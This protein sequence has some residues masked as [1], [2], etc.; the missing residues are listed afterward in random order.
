MSQVKDD[1]LNTR[2]CEL[3]G[4]DFPIVSAGMGFVARAE[5]AAAVSNAGGLGVIGGAG[6]APERLRFEI[7]KCRELTDRP[8]GVDLIL[9]IQTTGDVLPPR[10]VSERP[11]QMTSDDYDDGHGEFAIQHGRR[12]PPEESM[13]VVVEEEPPIFVSGLGNPGP[14]VDDLHKRGCKVMSLVG[15]ARA[16]RKVVE[17]GADVVIAQGTEGGGH[18]GRVATSALVPAVVRASDDVPVLAAGGITT[19]E[20]LIAALALGASGVWMGTRFVASEEAHGHLNYKEKIVEANEDST[21]ITR[22]YSGKT[23]RTIKNLWTKDWE[24]R[25]QDIL[26]FPDQFRNSKHV[27]VLARRDGDTDWGSMPCGQGAASITNILPAGEIV[28]NVILEAR[29]ALSSSI[30]NR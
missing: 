18:T 21:V 26:S 14:W 7:Q 13:R 16:A 15:T 19:G 25:P 27:Y 8:F 30:F 17:A 2:I 10:S 22:C 11:S 3:L 29:Q 1:P 23:L 12:I 9:P 5:L 4:V 28:R 24:S 20:G 6:F